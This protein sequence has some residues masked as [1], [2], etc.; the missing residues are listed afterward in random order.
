[1]PLPILPSQGAPPARSQYV[2]ETLRQAIVSGTLAPGERLLEREICQQ[3]QVSRTP[4]R[5]ALLRLQAEKLATEISG[6]GVQVAAHPRERIAHM[7][8]AREALE[9]MTA[10]LAAQWISEAQLVDLRNTVDAMERFAPDD[11]SSTWSDLHE[12]FHDIIYAASGNPEIVG[13][14]SSLTDNLKVYRHGRMPERMDWAR[15]KEE[16]RALFGALS[17]RDPDGAEAI[18][19]QHMRTALAVWL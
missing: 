13:L 19:R 1:M 11:L 6:G 5:W 15:V 17:R 9:G 7:F 8:A 18:M 4:V 16:I 12:H 14:L 10:R 3:L 2:Y